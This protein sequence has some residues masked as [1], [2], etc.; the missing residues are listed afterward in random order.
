MPPTNQVEVSGSVLRDMLLDQLWHKRCD[1]IPD[2]MPPF[3]QEYT[4][5]TVQIR[6][7]DGTDYP[8]F[9]RHSR[10]PRQGFEWDIYGDDFQ[11]V[12]LAVL[13]LSQAPYPRPVGPLV[14]TIPVSRRTQGGENAAD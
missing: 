10:G 2:Y 5:P 8:P 12:E 4:R 1:I 9:L 14:F 3:P 13:A 11:N 6:Y 7:N